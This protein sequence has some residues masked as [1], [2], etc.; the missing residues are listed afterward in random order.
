[1]KVC[2]RFIDFSQRKWRENDGIR[3]LA[4]EGAVDR[5]YLWEEFSMSI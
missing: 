1:M 2:H 3:V 4:A 5:V